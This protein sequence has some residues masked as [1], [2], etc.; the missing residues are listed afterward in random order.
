[1][2]QRVGNVVHDASSPSRI[3]AA[4]AS[5]KTSVL[6]QRLPGPR[7]DPCTVERDIHVPGQMLSL[8]WS[9][10]ETSQH[11]RA[12]LAPGGHPMPTFLSDARGC[13]S[14]GLGFE[15]WR[16]QPEMATKHHGVR[17]I[18]GHVDSPRSA[19]R[20]GT[21]DDNDAKFDR[22]VDGSTGRSLIDEGKL[23]DCQL[24]CQERVQLARNPSPRKRKRHIE[25]LRSHPE[26]GPK[27]LLGGP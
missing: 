18:D 14:L 4:T 6:R 23:N 3:Q 21:G 2:R 11:Q 27:P 1:M 26:T 12:I 13:R 8:A 19:K 25:K 24:R 9:S 20:L 15:V 10:S 16:I 7:T 17:E 5:Q 22:R